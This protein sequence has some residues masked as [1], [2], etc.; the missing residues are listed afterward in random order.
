MFEPLSVPELVQQDGLQ[1]H[2]LTAAVGIR[3][4]P[5]PTGRVAVDRHGRTLRLAKLQVREV[6]KRHSHAVQVRAGMCGDPFGLRRGK[7]RVELSHRDRCCVACRCSRRAGIAVDRRSGNGVDR[8]CWVGNRRSCDRRWSERVVLRLHRR[9]GSRRAHS[10]RRIV[11][12]RVDRLGIGRHTRARRRVGRDGRGVC[13]CGSGIGAWGCGAGGSSCGT[14]RRRYN[15]R[16]GSGVGKC[17]DRVVD[18]RGVRER[19]SG[20]IRRLRKRRRLHGVGV[21]DDREALTDHRQGPV[22]G[23]ARELP[24]PTLTSVRVPPRLRGESDRCL[25]VVVLRKRRRLERRE[26]VGGDRKRWE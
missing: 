18:H 16:D 15:R 11:C 7:R 26:A 23:V 3:D 8:R 1:V 13:R 6:G 2:V 10:L 19:V 21:G 4:R 9:S 5:T 12:R 17:A 24:T 20:R 25:R 14:R 22:S